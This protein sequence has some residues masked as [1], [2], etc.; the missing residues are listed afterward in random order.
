MEVIRAPSVEYRDE[1]PYVGI[2][3]RTPMVGMSDAVEALKKELDAELRGNG[4]IATGPCFLRLHVIDMKGI[5]DIEVGRP[6]DEARALGDRIRPGALPA[7]QY[8]NYVFA[9]P[10]IAGNGFL[11]RWI[12]EQGLQMD[13][14]EDP[15]GDAFRCR[16]ETFLTDPKLEHRRKKWEIEM[17][18]KL[19][20]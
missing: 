6:V 10:G 7:G 19:I 15:N 13:R 9:G 16:C 11:L 14:W 4:V 3:V 18:V 2:R 1:K 5:M 20:G 17:A 8:A 12:K